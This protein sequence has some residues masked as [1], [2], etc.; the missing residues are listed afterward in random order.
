MQ[1]TDAR[2]Y[3]V[4]VGYRF[5]T[6]KI[7][8]NRNTHTHTHARTHTHTRTRARTVGWIRPGFPLPLR[9]GFLYQRLKHI[10]KLYKTKP[11]PLLF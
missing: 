4:G 10:T 11:Q 1:R 9:W 3:K 7:T 8:Q 6:E 5:Y 2:V